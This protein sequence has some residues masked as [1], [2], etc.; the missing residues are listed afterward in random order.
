MSDS[1]MHCLL[2]QMT[3]Q[4]T[5]KYRYMQDNVSVLAVSDT[6]V[7]NAIWTSFANIVCS[8]S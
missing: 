4:S 2:R 7:K 3:A 1:I 6:G 5:V 8:V